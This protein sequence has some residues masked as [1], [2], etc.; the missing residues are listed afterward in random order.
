MLGRAGRLTPGGLRAAV[1]RAV[2]EVAPDKARKRRERAQRDARVQRWREDS[3]NAALV[4]RELPPDE[5]L[6]AD[7]RITW[8]AT[9]LK[10]AGLEGDMDVLRARAY[11]DLLLGKDSRPAAAARPPSA[12]T[13]TA[14]RTPSTGAPASP[15]TAAT[16]SPPTAATAT[17]PTTRPPTASPTARATA[18]TA[19]PAAAGPTA[20]ATKAGRTG[21]HRPDDPR[22]DGPE[23]PGGGPPAPDPGGAGVPPTAGVLPAGFAGRINLTIPLATLLRLAERPGELSG[24]GPVDPA[25][26]RDLA[27]AAAANP[28]TTWCVTVTD[29]HGH[30]TGHGCARPEPRTR[31]P[32]GHA[33]PG[34]HG[35]PTGP[36]P[37]G[38]HGPPGGHDP[39]GTGP[40]PGFTF[41]CHRWAR[42]ARRVR[43]LAAVHRN[44]RATGSAARPGPD[45]P[46]HV[47]SPVRGPR[48]RSRG[49]APAPDPD[50]ARHLYRADL[51]APLHPSRLRAQHPLRDR[52]PDVPVQ[53]RPDLPS[54]P[55]AQTAPPLESRANRPGHLP[56][57]RAVWSAVHH[58]TNP[59]PHMTSAD[60]LSQPAAYRSRRRCDLMS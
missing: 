16:A 30:A 59:V 40:L 57:N 10:K 7:Q 9:E 39:P 17:A 12:R 58:R 44:P 6:A 24:L 25:L 52:R 32:G 20:R 49:Q 37:P 43:Y 56:P 46:R 60:C 14:A 48:P 50:P 33:P 26:A 38:D 53:R 29:Q 55:P 36:A 34:D 27:R 21:K 4:G 15:P 8:W 22:G 19:N 31:P 5:V 3:G 18:R 1:A 13:V 2:I 54:R 28:T 35:P 23:G 11:L 51:P 47:R 42:A 45:R 41:T